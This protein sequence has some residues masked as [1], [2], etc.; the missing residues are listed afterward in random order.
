M[1]IDETISYLNQNTVLTNSVADIQRPLKRKKVL[2]LGGANVG[3]SAL[4][5]RFLENIFLDFYEPTLQHTQKK[6]I[7]FHKESIELE[8]VDIDG[9]SKY[10]IFNYNK[11][12]KGIHGYLLIY[13]I[14]NKDSFE[15]VKK[16]NSKLNS[17]VGSG[18]PRVLVGT[19]ND[20]QRQVKYEEGKAFAENIGCPFIETTAK[21]DNDNNV[22]KSFLLLIIEINK[23]DVNF[24]TQSL[25]CLSTY[26]WFIRHK[27]LMKIVYYILMII[28]CLIGCGVLSLCLYFP[29]VI[30]YNFFIYRY[31]IVYLP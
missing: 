21:N 26:T 12:A 27:K 8:I 5:A 20:L 31:L 11:F 3:K 22:K 23:K 18:V 10:T 9:C 14:A 15:L 16:L 13:N 17:L 30:L 25:N 2:L 7:H 4:V 28:N 29:N 19:Q 1:E 6:D 24:S